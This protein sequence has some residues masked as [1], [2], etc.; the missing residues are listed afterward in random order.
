MRKSVPTETDGRGKRGEV[1]NNGDYEM[2][3]KRKM[4]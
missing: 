1:S 2:V 4:E 3:G